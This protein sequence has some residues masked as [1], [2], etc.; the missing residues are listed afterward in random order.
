MNKKL[1][2]LIATLFVSTK[3]FATAYDGLFDIKINDWYF[4][5]QWGLKND[6][7]YVSEKQSYYRI[8]NLINNNY[9]FLSKQKDSINVC[10]M[11][12]E[13]ADVIEYCFNENDIIEYEF[14]NQKEFSDYIYDR[15][16]REYNLSEKEKSFYLYSLKVPQT[17]GDIYNHLA[18][19]SFNSFT[20]VQNGFYI[21]YFLNLNQM[22]EINQ[23]KYKMYK[24]KIKYNLQ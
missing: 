12:I 2:I 10:I 5:V 3:I 9:E 22:K 21:Y 19:I 1:I 7:D 18:Q 4:S 20:E 14:K 11:K 17:D 24:Q 13:N 16:I 23:K 15:L 8:L 6:L